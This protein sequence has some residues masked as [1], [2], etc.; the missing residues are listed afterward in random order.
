MNA[1]KKLALFLW[2]IAMALPQTA[3][4]QSAALSKTWAGTWHLKGGPTDDVM[5]FNRT[6]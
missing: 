2:A 1:P 5:V 3:S 6:K 4:A